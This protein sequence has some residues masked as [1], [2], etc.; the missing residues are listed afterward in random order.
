MAAYLVALLRDPRLV[1][2]VS[3][4]KRSPSGIAFASGVRRCTPV[5]TVLASATPPSP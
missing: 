2:E 1:G 4:I 3:A 5:L